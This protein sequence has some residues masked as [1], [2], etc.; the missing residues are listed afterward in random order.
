MIPLDVQVAHYTPAIFPL[1][2]MISP[3]I[4]KLCEDSWKKIV[5][6]KEMTDSGTLWKLQS[7]PI[8]F[9]NSFHHYSYRQVLN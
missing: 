7:S 9:S 6:N 2:P 4:N 3:K 5:A 1:V 8:R